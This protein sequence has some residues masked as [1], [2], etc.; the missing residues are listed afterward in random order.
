MEYLSFRHGR[1]TYAVALHHVRYIAAD[2]S[3]PVVKVAHGG[4]PPVDVVEFENQPCR[5]V[6][7][8]DLIGHTEDKQQTEAL[9]ELLHQREQDHL[10]WLNALEKALKEN[11]EFTLARDP[12]ACAF[13]RWYATFKPD[14]AEL[15]HVMEKFDQPHKRIHALAD[16]LLELEAEG[17]VED[18]LSQLQH[19]RN[20]TL[21]RLQELFA[22]ARNLASGNIRPTVIMLQTG[23][24]KLTAL[25]VDEIGEVFSADQPVDQDSSTSMMPDFAE[26]W[27]KD[28]KLS[29]KHNTTTLVIAP[30][31]LERL[32]A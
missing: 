16:E 17:R 2:T 30:Q 27:L 3:L 25:L 4:G 8:R 24:A 28:V 7:M 6:A 5:L 12:S 32:A 1:H 22:E 14:N 26:G 15:A 29:Q 18:A 13:G 11:T 9:V 23:D 10:N 31:R 19:H 20:T 21:H